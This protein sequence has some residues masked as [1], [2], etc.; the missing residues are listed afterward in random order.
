[1]ASF[2]PDNSPS[3]EAVP[4]CPA[5]PCGSS[6][7]AVSHAKASCVHGFSAAGPRKPLLLFTWLA[8]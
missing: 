1:M 6:A 3:K 4:G 5:V 7:A 2:N 8:P